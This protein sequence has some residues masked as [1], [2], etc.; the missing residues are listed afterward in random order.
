MNI[1]FDQRQ[2]P[3]FLFFPPNVSLHRGQKQQQQRKRLIS[4]LLCVP[5]R[6]ANFLCVLKYDDLYYARNE[7]SCFTFFGLPGCQ[8]EVELPCKT[9]AINIFFARLVCITYNLLTMKHQISN[10]LNWSFLTVGDRKRKK[11]MDVACSFQVIVFKTKI[12]SAGRNPL[13]HSICYQEYLPISLSNF[14][15]IKW[16]TEVIRE[17]LGLSSI[18]DTL[19]KEHPRLFTRILSFDASSRLNMTMLQFPLLANSDSK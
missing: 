8:L 12:L 10:S 1:E 5:G 7:E 2:K 15:L 13:G 6:A 19:Y 9:F 17:K 18:G 11:C 16:K 14:Y 3:K 4:S